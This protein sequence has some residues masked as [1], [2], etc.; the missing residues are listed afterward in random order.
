L[1]RNR[2]ESTMA[3]ESP[4]AKNDIHTGVIG[5]RL[6]L[7]GQ[8][9]AYAAATITRHVA[10]MAHL[11]DTCFQA[12]TLAFAD[13]CPTGL[14]VQLHGFESENHSGTRADVIASAGSPS[15]EPWLDDVVQQLK[16]A[17]ALTVL[18]YPRD[19]RQLGAT[20]N[21]QGEALHQSR[22][23]RFLHLEMT[24]ELRDQ[25]TRDDQLRRAILNT[26]PAA[27]K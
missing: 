8:T 19:T 27:Q 21:A 10:D 4:H 2:P 9:R 23:C 26:L 1:F 17:T 11:E 18:A 12:F 24:K 22:R 5:L 14:V 25:L 7:A 16:Q 6:F 3:L 15:P 13:V 20:R